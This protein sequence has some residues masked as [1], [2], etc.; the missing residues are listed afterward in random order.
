MWIIPSLHLTKV[1]WSNERMK[2]KLS[3]QS[4]RTSRY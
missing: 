2:R 4:S 3:K 1:Q